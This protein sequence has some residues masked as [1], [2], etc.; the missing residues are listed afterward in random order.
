MNNFQQ[1]QQQ[2]QQQSQQQQQQQQQLQQQQAN[3]QARL[4]PSGM[5]TFQQS[6]LSPRVS[7]VSMLFIS[8][9]NKLLICIS[10]LVILLSKMS[11]IG[12]WRL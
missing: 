8:Y 9:V 10:C 6:Q 2:Q 3:A 4:S 11:S 1:Q 7:Q 12:F 5:A